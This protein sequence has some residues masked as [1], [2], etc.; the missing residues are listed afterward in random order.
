MNNYAAKFFLLWLLPV[1]FIF[2]AYTCQDHEDDVPLRPVYNYDYYVL[3]LDLTTG[4]SQ[5]LAK[6]VFSHISPQS[7]KVFFSL[8]YERGLFSVNM[9][10]SDKKMLIDSSK[11]VIHNWLFT[12]DGKKIIFMTSDGYNDILYTMNT[13]GSGLTK[14]FNNTASIFDYSPELNRILIGSAYSLEMIDINGNNYTYLTGADN[15]TSHI[16]SAKFLPDNKGIIYL[17]DITSIQIFPAVLQKSIIKTLSLSS[18]EKTSL[19]SFNVWVTDLELSHDGI[20]LMS[21]Y[22]NG[23]RTIIADINNNYKSAEIL[24]G[25]RRSSFSQDGKTIVSVYSNTFHLM[26]SDGSNGRSISERKNS[27]IMSDKPEITNDGK[28][29]IYWARCDSIKS[30]ERSFKDL[31]PF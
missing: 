9:D 23:D 5:T 22:K 2:T 10:G 21:G 13:D 8:D 28:R 17:Q 6:G 12:P 16:I 29:I 11:R 31:Q 14:I 1:S 7:D 24:Q 15:D 30:Y 25:Y 19:G 20:L 18:L 4:D 26:H 27:L 3:S